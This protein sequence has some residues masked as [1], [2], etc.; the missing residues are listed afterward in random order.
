MTVQIVIGVV[1]FSV[2]VLSL[3]AIVLGARRWLVP[4]G[5]VRIQ[6]N[7]DPSKSLV[8]PTGGRLLGTL[9]AHQIFVPSACGG[10]G[11]C[12][13]CR[14]KVHQGGGDVLATERNFLSRREIRDGVRLSC[15]V[16]VKQDLTIEIP[17][18]VFDIK[19][20]EC[21]VRSNRNVATFIKE[22]VL[23]LPPGE[24]VEFKAGG[25]IQ[26]VCPPH[27]VDYR[28]FEIEERFREDWDKYDVWRYRSKVTETVSRAYSMANYPGEKGIIML[29]VRI[30]TPPPNAPNA[31]PG[32]MSS[33]IFGLKPGDKVTISGPYGQ[34]FIKDTDA[35]MIYIGGGAGMAPLRSHLFELLKRSQSNRKI[36]YW[37][38]ARSLREAFYTEEFER[39][40][41]ENPN[42]QWHLALSEPLP[43][44][45]WEGP[46]GFVHQVLFEHYLKEHPSP[47][48]VEYYFCG[49][50]MMNTAVVNLLDRMGV[51][52]ENIAF[53]DFGL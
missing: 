33:Y 42:F 3:V 39:L 22:L 30:A 11:T 2:I 32:K 36:S 52:E 29:N 5:E 34:F 35:E 13:E 4:S 51:E 19:Q 50:P 41:R 45:R 9:A 23:E 18:E 20:W 43:E 28:T 1:A 40:A 53:D 7:E 26:I 15:Q 44:D 8:V 6:I 10:Q 49:P 14:I 12:A 31:P 21:T 25:Y 48:D 38:G 16:A 24:E 27:E 47:E 46:V 37:Y 17:A